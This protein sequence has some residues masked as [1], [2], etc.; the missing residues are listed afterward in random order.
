MHRVD[1]KNLVNIFKKFILKDDDILDIGCGNGDNMAIL[2]G[3]GFLNITGSDISNEMLNICR[4]R[5]MQT[6][7]IKELEKS[8]V[9]Y[10]VLLISHVIEHIA[11]PDIIEFIKFYISKLRDGGKVIIITPLLSNKFYTDIDHIKPYNIDALLQ[12]FNSAPERS[13]AYSKLEGFD[14]IDIKFRRE[15]LDYLNNRARYIKHPLNNVINITLKIAAE[16]AKVLSFGVI[17]R[18]TGYIA[19]LQKLPNA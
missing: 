18:S 7:E 11:Y 9:K 4:N 6:I 12:L 13:Q 15:R 8:T 14:L 10:D 17:A 2:Q 1:V 16:A 19:I 5:K 3:Q